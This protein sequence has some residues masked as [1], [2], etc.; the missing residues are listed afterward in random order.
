MLTCQTTG[1]GPDDLFNEDLFP[2]TDSSDGFASD[3]F[4]GSDPFA[5]DVFF[6][7]ANGEAENAC[8]EAD[9]S[10]SCAENKASTGT[11]CFESE[12]PDEDSDIEI[13]YSREDLDAIA[14]GDDSSGFKP[15]QSSSEEL[16]PEPV[17]DRRCP[18]QCSVES[19][20]SG[21]ELDLCPVSSP[22]KMDEHQHGPGAEEASVEDAADQ[23]S[24]C[25]SAHHR[26]HHHHHH[27]SDRTMPEPEWISDKK[28]PVPHD[29]TSMLVTEEIKI[30]AEEARNA[31]SPL[32]T[33][34]PLKQVI[35]QSDSEQNDLDLS[36]SSACPASFDP[37]GFKLSPENSS[38]TLVDP[39][40]AEL[41]PEQA[42]NATIFD[43]EPTSPPPYEL[44]FDP[45]GFD[46]TACQ[47]VRDSD[48]YGFKL[49]PDEENQVDLD[50]CDDH[51]L[52]EMVLTTHENDEELENFNYANQEVLKPQTYENQ[53][54]LEE[55]DYTLKE[56]PN[57]ESFGNQEVLEPSLNNELLTSEQ[58][59][60]T[61]YSSY[62][63]QEVVETCP[64]INKEVLPEPLSYNNQE[65]VEP[66]NSGSN[67]LQEFSYPENQEVLDLDNYG[68]QE[69]LG[70]HETEN[71]TTL[72]S[73]VHLDEPQDLGVTENQKFENLCSHDNQETLDLF[74]HESAAGVKRYQGIVETDLNRS[75]SSN[76]SDS[77]LASNNV[78]RP[79]PC[80]TNVSS[81]NSI[82][83][84]ST[85][86]LQQ[87]ISSRS[88]TQDS[89]PSESPNT[90][91]LF[92]ADLGAVFEAGGY[93]AC[94]DVADDLEPLNR[95]QQT[96]PQRSAPD[97][98]QPRRP[99][100]PP[101]PSLKNKEKATSGGIDLK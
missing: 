100:R 53:E 64:I 37:Y 71:K 2:K 93:V 84:A 74:S 34:D 48:P 13:S 47:I 60:L 61:D 92:G 9:T 3:P 41:S 66:N 25:V 80:S 62:E 38:H 54:V 46:I 26:H 86:A 17:K 39:D 7:S 8:D 42:E 68:N 89:R 57:Y 72:I 52:E 69:L 49:S 4:K 55:Y 44:T 81:V 76:S 43:D 91:M 40:E 101:R 59:E 24:S 22:S 51:N 98:V 82:I 33:L 88:T 77:E 20:P 63:N 11:Q 96:P 29:L 1:D 28:Q 15:I 73:D 27:H 99:V 30:D 94:P 75:L 97:L 85:Y 35:L 45:Y 87:A 14:V 36:Y 10:L 21:Y 50:L 83:A 23:G 95:C 58:K 90:Q 31:E 70:F 65:W 79:E 6:P 12:F 18:G 5:K 32:S 16:M 78:Q 56:V 67:E 19:D